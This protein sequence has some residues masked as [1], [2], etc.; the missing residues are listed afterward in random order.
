VPASR[1]RLDADGDLA[2]GRSGHGDLGGGEDLGSSELGV[3]DGGA[4]IGCNR[5]RGGT[6]YA[7]AHLARARWLLEEYRVSL[8][9]QQLGTAEQVSLQRVTKPPASL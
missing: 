8:F 6:Y 2:G 3:H 1:G 7:A 4:H 5:G 9:A